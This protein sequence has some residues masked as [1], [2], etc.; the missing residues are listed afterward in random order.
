MANSG[1]D[2][3]G[4]QFFITVVRTEWLDNKH[5]LFGMVVMGIDVLMAISEVETDSSDRPLTDVVIN[6]ISIENDF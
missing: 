2:T 3:G 5:S 6:S 1:P 4:S